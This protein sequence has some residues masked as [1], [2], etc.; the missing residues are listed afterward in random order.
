MVVKNKSFSLMIFWTN[1]FKNGLNFRA[2][3]TPAWQSRASI[4]HHHHLLLVSLYVDIMYIRMPGQLYM[5]KSCSVS[6]RVVTSMICILFLLCRREALGSILVKYFNSTI[7][8]L[9]WNLELHFHGNL[10]FQKLKITSSTIYVNS[11]AT[12]H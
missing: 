8:F 7:F 4:H 9:L 1:I 10:K 6:V 3:I 11:L 2:L 5:K 12:K